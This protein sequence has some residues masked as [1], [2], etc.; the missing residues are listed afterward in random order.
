MS[1]LTQ[2]SQIIS[3]LSKIISNFIPLLKPVTS[4]NQ[5]WSHRWP[6]SYFS[7]QSVMTFY[8]HILITINIHCVSKKPHHFT[9]TPSRMTNDPFYVSLCPCS[10]SPRT[11][12][13]GSTPA[14]RPPTS[15]TVWRTERRLSLGPLAWTRTGKQV[16]H[17]DTAPGTRCVL[18]ATLPLLPWFSL[19]LCE[20]LGS[21][22]WILSGLRL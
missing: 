4:S 13:T 22:L 3:H 5:P 8:C 16:G 17:A 14:G 11:S 1:S 12:S 2:P 18:S 15:T 21:V 7:H 10:T 19:C 9:P 20:K 6:C